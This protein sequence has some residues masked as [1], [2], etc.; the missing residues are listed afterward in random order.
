[1]DCKH[2][3]TDGNITKY[4]VCKVYNKQLDEKKCKNCML[5]NPSFPEEF[6]ELFKGLW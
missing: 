6:K 4:Y 3:K 2:T 1:M 5:K